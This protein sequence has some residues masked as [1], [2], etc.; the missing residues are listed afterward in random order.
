MSKQRSR[1]TKN[2]H[3]P[4]KP[5]N[6]PKWHRDVDRWLFKY[7]DA[8]ERIANLEEQLEELNE[9]GQRT[10]MR[11]ELM[12][13]QRSLSPSTPVEDL[14]LKKR[15]IEER[16]KTARLTR[17]TIERVLD[18]AFIRSELNQV[19]PFIEWHWWTR[20]WETERIR[21][22]L[23]TLNL[24]WVSE[25]Q[26]FRIRHRIYERLGEVLGMK[27]EPPIEGQEVGN[28]SIQAGN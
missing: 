12:E 4:G 21:R 5:Y 20:P 14:A 28:E 22:A 15:T 6:R 3:Q 1:Y 19:L 16:I 26:Y 10:V 17:L 7:P 13:G 9:L 27:P 25:R 2:R 24:E 23:V 8:A 18:Y 11:Y